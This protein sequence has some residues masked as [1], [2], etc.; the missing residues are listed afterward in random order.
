MDEKKDALV[1]GGHEFSSRFILGSGK[2]SLK[3][4]TGSV[5][6]KRFEHRAVCFGNKSN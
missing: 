1:I 3:V 4:V 2:Y 5:P 6:P